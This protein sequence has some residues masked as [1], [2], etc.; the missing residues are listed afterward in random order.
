MNSSE[1]QKDR[2]DAKAMTTRRIVIEI[3][4]N[5]YGMNPNR[6]TKEWIEERLEI[7][8]QYTLKSLKKQSNQ[9]VI[10]VVKLAEGCKEIVEEALQ[11]AEPYPENIIFGTSHESNRRL[12]LIFKDLM[13]YM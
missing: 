9:N 11:K 5:N 12:K 2:K 8:H 13:S 4:F 6:L 1:P 7:F 10:T 3:N